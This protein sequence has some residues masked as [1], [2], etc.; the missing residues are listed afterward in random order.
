MG[1]GGT[2]FKPRC[3]TSECEP[4]TALPGQCVASWSYPLV[5]V[6]WSSR[7]AGQGYMEG[8]GSTLTKECLDGDA[9][10]DA[11]EEESK[12]GQI[13]RADKG[14]VTHSLSVGVWPSDP[15]KEN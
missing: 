4:I 15:A 8:V 11:C 5:L 12:T 9:E 6:F 7:E 2:L 1:A 3:A 13:T 10:G 14:N